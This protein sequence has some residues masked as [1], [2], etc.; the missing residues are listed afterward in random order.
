MAKKTN[1][2]LR[3]KVTQPHIRGMATA[4][5][6]E[7]T[8]R[9]GSNQHYIFAANH[10]DYYENTR[11]AEE[12]LIDHMNEKALRSMFASGRNLLAEMTPIMLFG[13]VTI[14]LLRQY[15]DAHMHSDERMRNA[16]NNAMATIGN[17]LALLIFQDP[18]NLI[19]EDYT[20]VDFL[21][22]RRNLEAFES[23][24][25]FAYRPPEYGKDI[26]GKRKPILELCPA[27]KLGRH[28]VRA[29]FEILYG[30]VAARNPGQAALA[31]IYLDLQSGEPPMCECL[32]VRQRVGAVGK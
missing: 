12:G 3:F 5:F 9:I 8:T 16:L 25:V 32:L 26:D 31:R 17:N 30:F 18:R 11:R 2:P 22:W 19:A 21:R 27:P 20:V 29:G 6:P 7:F 24:D 13:F 10:P 4:D 23:T 14:R 15:V 1:K 28:L